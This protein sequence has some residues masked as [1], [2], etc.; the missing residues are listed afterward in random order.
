M[1]S[2]IRGVSHIQPC[3][4][5]QVPDVYDFFGFPLPFNPKIC[6]AMRTACIYVRSCPPLSYCAA[7]AHT[8]HAN[9]CK[10]R[11]GIYNISH[12]DSS[13][14]PWVFYTYFYN[15][16]RRLRLEKLLGPCGPAARSDPPVFY[17]RSSWCLLRPPRALRSFWC[18]SRSP[19]V[20]SGA[21]GVSWILQ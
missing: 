14:T 10:W 16:A 4:G 8:H 12:L 1:R 9:L 13:L 2:A 7:R 21:L 20:S 5:C 17:L 3:T 6:Q 11:A 19:R 15:H 18:P